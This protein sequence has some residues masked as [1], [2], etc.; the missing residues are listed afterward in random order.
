MKVDTK[1]RVL[2]TLSAYNT[3]INNFP[4]LIGMDYNGSGENASAPVTFLLDIGGLFGLGR[5]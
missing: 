5:D 4:T 1:T 3:L 2:S